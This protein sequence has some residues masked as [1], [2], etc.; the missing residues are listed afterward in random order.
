M[1]MSA[2]VRANMKADRLQR[3]WEALDVEIVRLQRRQ[4]ALRERVIVA[5]RERDA[6][7]RAHR[8]RTR[9]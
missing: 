9:A 1:T 2:R 6:L 8:R 3:Q 7:D 4:T 5:E